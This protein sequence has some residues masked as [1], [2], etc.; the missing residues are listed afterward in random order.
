MACKN[1]LLMN[2]H[3]PVAD[4]VLGHEHLQ[5]TIDAIQNS[6]YLNDSEKYS[7]LCLFDV[8]IGGSS[9]EIMQ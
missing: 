4:Y 1:V 3:G 5:N 7:S 9:S 6:F 8:T 2:A